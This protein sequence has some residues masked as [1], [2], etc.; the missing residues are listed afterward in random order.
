VATVAPFRGL[1]YSAS[2][3]PDLTT[4]VAPPYDVISTEKAQEYRARDSHNI[5]HVD[6]PAGEAPGR[7]ARAA[8]ML[9]RWREEG[10]LERDNAP[11]LY[12][13]SQRYS[14]RGMPEKV[15]WGFIGLLRI[16]E[17]GSAVVLPHEKTHDEPRADRLDLILATRGQI[18]PIF[19][20][21]S[22]P[23]GEISSTIEAVSHR[24]ADRWVSDD[25]GV[26]TRMWRMGDPE[27]IGS[28]C[29][30]LRERKIWIADGHHR[31]AAAREARDRLRAGQ[32]AAPP[33]SLSYD[34][35]LAYFSNVDAP[36]L[37][38]L[39]YHRVLR[40]LKRTDLTHLP[41]KLETHFDLKHF[42]FE[43]FNHRAEQ[44]RRRLRE[45]TDRG[46]LAVAL[47]SGGAGFMLLLLKPGQLT[48]PLLADL[49][50]PLRELD[51]SVLQRA[52]L[53][54]SLGFT[55]GAQREGT[56]LR[57]TEDVE[58]AMSWV[59]AGEGQAAFLLN[60]PRRHQMLEAAEAGLRM[61]QKST[62]FYPKVLTGLV[63]NAFDP[64]E[65]VH[66]VAQGSSHA[67]TAAK[68]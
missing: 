15:R 9:S 35:V 8:Q 60:P 11:A 5:V 66:S 49:P 29:G 61:P 31:Y 51:V 6:L 50:A 1:L 36:G 63:I 38:I 18:S 20:L 40:G 48:G 14:V 56:S 62:Y 53:E 24:P 22:D 37:T 52:V 54:A 19:V 46:R 43:G 17:E 21:F 58:R 45:V 47:Y 16:E 57:Y 64:A 3:I 34:Y 13:T 32:T 30:A 7:Y 27:T 65:E 28:I 26:D 42:S 33:G 59:D 68:G 4:V 44:V 25:A 39:P 10:V 55:P 41:R 12:V 67:P 2:R 23:P